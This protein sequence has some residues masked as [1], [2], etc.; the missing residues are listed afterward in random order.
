VHHLFQELGKRGRRLRHDVFDFISEFGIHLSLQL[1]DINRTSVVGHDV[2]TV[3][4][5]IKDNLKLS[6]V[7]GTNESSVLLFSE[8]TL[9][10]SSDNSFWVAIVDV[11]P[12]HFQLKDLHFYQTNYY[13]Y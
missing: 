6:K 12:N 2:L 10:K 7:V 13:I 3:V 8:E 5:L 11:L 4:S 1:V 9:R